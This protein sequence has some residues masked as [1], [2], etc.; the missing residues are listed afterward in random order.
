MGRAIVTT[1]KRAWS[2]A[3]RPAFIVLLIALVPIGVVLIR[4]LV[5]ATSNTI[6]VNT[7]D[8]P[9]NSSECSL[10]GAIENANSEGTNPSDSNCT[11][12]TGTDTINFSLPAFSTITLAGTL[13]TIA[14]ILTIDGTGQ[15]IT[16]DG[17]SASQILVV[18]GGAALTVN[19]LTLAHGHTSGD[20]G[21][22]YNNGGT[23]TVTNST[24]SANTSSLNAGGIFN[25]GTAS[26]TNSTFSD[27][28]G[29]YS[30]ALQSQYGGPLTVTNCT[31]SG[32]I[33]TLGNTYGAGVILN[34]AGATFYNSILAN[35]SGGNCTTG[36]SS[37]LPTDGGYN[38][39]D[40]GTCFFSATGS[41]NNL[42]PRLDPNGLENNGGPTE[43]ISLQ[44]GSP[45]IDVVPPAS[46]TV[47]TDQRGATRPFDGQ[48]NCDIGAFEGD[49]V[50]LTGFV[51]GSLTG[52]SGS[53]VTL[54]AAGSSGY[55]AGATVLGMTTS[56][57]LGA[58]S[59]TFPRS[60]PGNP[61]TYIT[62]T[63]GDAGGGANSA[64]G[65][66][67]A[68]GPASRLS[69]STII[70][71]NELTTA[72]AEWPLTPFLDSTGRILGAPASNTLGLKN[73]YIGFANLAD[74]NPSTLSV[75]GNPSLFLPS[76]GLCPGPV[77]CD[78]LERLNTL[79][80]I[81]AGCVESAS[82]FTACA[83]LFSDS[84]NSPT[85]TL[86]AAYQIV[87]NPAYNVSALYGLAS[88]PFSPAL[89]SAPDGW[90]MALNFN[91]NNTLPGGLFDHFPIAIAL[92]ASG[93]VFVA[94]VDGGFDFN[95]SVS[96]LT[97]ASD[98]R[99]GLSF[100]NGN[101]DAEFY[102]PFAIALDTSGNVFVANI[103]GGFDF[104][105]SVSE[106]TA[107][108][109]Y[110]GLSFDDTTG[111]MFDAPVS[112]ALDVSGNLFA[113]NCGLYCSG[114]GYG[115]GS[116]SEL[117]EASSYTTGLNLDPSG[118]S[119]DAPVWLALDK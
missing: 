52:I 39:S 67:A 86:G 119:F 74:I 43:T 100:D 72:A 113:A 115:P 84:S 30:G 108:D 33:A 45:A 69:D 56:G 26:V 95:G 6:I 40:D 118:A 37:T 63:G 17:A 8:D 7:T 103:G 109:Y 21:A 38:I 16:V 106:L 101:T 92:D 94:N 64:I 11:A 27:N 34:Y 93:N 79:A 66:M 85:D 114:S 70:V 49:N 50:T 15:T 87:A 91:D 99:T 10:H 51:M 58:F 75:S 4:T 68:L 97:A 18:N 61:Q 19:D 41:H 104:N 96:E 65:L 57:A 12:G 1:C 36:S 35:S 77:N 80:N 81:L 47:A 62:A 29:A 23:L 102:Q 107:G 24:F 31:F 83:T 90:E 48:T 59:L 111:A 73:A 28:S 82:P 78:G 76:G 44:P 42:L 3:A 112:L 46:C 2:G 14:H 32:N 110:N 55:G 20:G 25:A 89:G 53:T 9:G 5:R 22:I 60:V 54:Y 116:V 88:G 71:I 13:P 105:G 98:Y 117:T